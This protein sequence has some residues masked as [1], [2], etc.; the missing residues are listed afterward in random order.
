MIPH[1]F[2]NLLRRRLENQ[3]G[4]C[5]DN[6]RSACQREIKEDGGEKGV[7]RWKEKIR[8]ERGG[9]GLSPEEFH[10]ATHNSIIGGGGKE[11]EEEARIIIQT[12]GRSDC[13][14][15]KLRMS[16][17]WIHECYAHVA[18]HGTLCT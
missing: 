17:G 16:V 9:R 3:G 8:R 18:S 13:S 1:P 12:S 2:S 7:E 5:R 15:E 14:K 4:S 6:G 11:R 10:P